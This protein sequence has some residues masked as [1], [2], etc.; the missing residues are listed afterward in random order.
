M[1]ILETRR[2]LIRRFVM[3][4][5][6][7]IHGVL[8]AAFK[9][10]TTVDD[11]I[12]WLRWSVM[13]Y[14]QLEGLHQPPYGDRAVV[15]KES[16]QVIGS[17]GF[18]PCLM[19]FGQLPYFAAARLHAAN[20]LHGVRA[21]LGGRSR[22]SAAR[23]RHRGSAGN[24]RRRLYAAAPGPDRRHHGLR[25]HRVPR[26]DAEPGHAKSSA[27]RWPSPNGCRSSGSWRTPPPDRGLTAAAQ[28]G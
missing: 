5:L 28:G 26:G 1:D 4:D 23:L 12:P 16:G 9:T 15:L 2:L 14:D 24:D 17:V 22:A 8:S 3:E 21:V 11:L 20:Q 6:A 19:P 7:G 27:T 25:Q 18:V 13:N 10:D